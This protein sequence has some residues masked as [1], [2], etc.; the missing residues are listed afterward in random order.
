MWLRSAKS[1][2]LTRLPWEDAL[3][4]ILHGHRHQPSVLCLRQLAPFSSVMAKPVLPPLPD[5]GP[6]PAE[7][8]IA[9]EPA[10]PSRK[11]F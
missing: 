9:A 6:E 2:S 1:R 5:R 11:G 8:P 7:N 4:S 3:R 10:V